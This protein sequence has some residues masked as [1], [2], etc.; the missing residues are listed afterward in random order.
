VECRSIR[1]SS[2]SDLWAKSTG[3]SIAAHTLRVLRNLRQIRE[4]SPDLDRLCASPRFWVRVALAVCLHD[5]GKCCEGFQKLVHQGTRFPHRHEV[6]SALFV[7]WILHDNAAE[8]APWI[9]AAILTH[10][11]DWP[12]IDQK[13]PPADFY[14]DEL[15]GLEALRPEMSDEFFQSAENIVRAEIWPEFSST[16]LFP[17]AWTQGVL[18]GWI[19][20]DPV[21]ELRSTIE[22]ARALIRQ[23]EQLASTAS[24]VIGGTLLRGSV[25]LADHSGSAWEHFR[26]LPRLRLGIPK[27]GTLYSH[28][29]Q[30]EKHQG[31]A[32][33]IAPTGS[34][35]TEAALLWISGQA[36]LV[37]GNPVVYYLLPYQASLNA[38]RQRLALLF[39]DEFVTLQHSRAVQAI[40]RQLLDKEYNAEDA[41]RVAKRERN[42]ASL[43]VKP[44]RISTPYQLLKGAF[45][46]K[47]HETLWTAATSALF[48]LDEIHVYETARL[49]I[50]LATLRHLCVTLGGR[51]LVMSATLPSYL[52]DVLDGILP[53]LKTFR[54]DARTLEKFCRHEIRLLD[55]N[56]LDESIVAAVCADAA[57]GLSVL[58]VATTVGR[59]Q[60]I[61]RKLRGRACCPVE[62]LHGRFHADDRA[63][64]ES[65]LLAA[66]GVGTSSPKPSIILVA[67]QVVEVS[68]NVDFDVLY[69][70][71]APLEALLQRFGRVNRERLVPMRTVNVCRKLPEG[72]PVY[73]EALVRKALNALESYDGKQLEE[74]HIQAMLDGIYDGKLGEELAMNLREGIER[75]SKHVLS[76]CRPFSSDEKIE[77][78]F[79][80]MF[81][82]YE[83]LPSLLS[84]EYERRLEETPLLAPGLLIPITRGQYFSLKSRNRL[85]RVD[86]TIIANCPYTEQGLEVYASPNQ[87]GI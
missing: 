64:K 16:W 40:Y 32:I 83:V 2:L 50:M 55:G 65:E 27:A 10:H 48:I 30:L 12:E 54:A 46:L 79:E 68:L 8:D 14:D 75:F 85:R 52:V 71:P 26:V 39:G 25:I 74:R 22:S 84:A 31:N 23:N 43:H 73:S 4:R 38:M 44:L 61:W 72:N 60:E 9:A 80:E 11:K 6:L 33:L 62:L 69:S 51:A 47:G 7:S 41:E 67:T 5:L 17:E 81:D 1:V 76:T 86:R 66:R 37:Q 21:Q 35:K 3:E 29:V 59:A 56:L 57:N 36:A 77:E 13:Y 53:G 20:K 45:Q 82:G 87:D 34:G 78:L 42:L 58:V 63:K 49:A 15:D 70:D 24:E 18:Q 28:Q 19:P